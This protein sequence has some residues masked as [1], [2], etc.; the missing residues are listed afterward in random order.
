MDYRG[1]EA[2]DWEFTYEGLHVVNRVF[3]VDGTGHSLFFQ[4]SEGDFADARADFDE[5]AA[6]FRPAGG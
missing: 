5:I 1:Y 2:A 3:V 6:A 4:T